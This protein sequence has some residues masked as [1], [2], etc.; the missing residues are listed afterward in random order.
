MILSFSFDHSRC[1]YNYWYCNCLEMPDKFDFN[2]QMIIR[3]VHVNQWN[4]LIVLV[5]VSN[6]WFIIFDG[7]VCMYW[8]VSKNRY[9]YSCYNLKKVLIPFVIIVLILNADVLINQCQYWPILWYLELHT[10]HVEKFYTQV[11]LCF[12]LIIA[13]SAVGVFTFRHIDLIIPSH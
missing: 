5:S 12:N 4:D 7:P 9:I 11:D 8:K 6:I 13:L 2:Q 10:L 1:S 3:Y